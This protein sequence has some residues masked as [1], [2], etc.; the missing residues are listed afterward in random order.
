MTT[1]NALRVVTRV[2]PGGKIE[3][4]NNQLPAGQEV[5]VVVLFPT[6]N[7]APRVSLLDVLADAPGGLVFRSAEEVDAH[8]K[9][10]RDAWER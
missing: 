7:N 1:Q 9:E 5:D 8:I 2:L 4:T 10:E 6:E 3:F